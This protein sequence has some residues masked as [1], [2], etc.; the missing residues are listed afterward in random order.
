[1][2]KNQKQAALT[3][4]ELLK[5]EKT[6]AE[7]E[8]NKKNYEEFEYKLGINS[9]NGLIDD[10]KNQLNSYDSLIEGNFHCLQPKSLDDIPNLLIAARLA[11][12]L[13]HKELGEKLGLKE[14]QIQRYEATDYETAAWARIS[15]VSRALNLMCYF[16]KVIIVNSENSSEDFKYPQGINKSQVDEAKERIKTHGSLI[17]A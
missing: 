5:L 7:F 1:M 11:Q 9:L 12:K 2:I 10:L 3:R 6:K 15:E 16:E 17:F 14:Q 4:Q 8:S 13:S